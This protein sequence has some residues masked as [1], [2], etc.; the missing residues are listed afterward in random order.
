MATHISR[1]NG[2]L[3]YQTI[4]QMVEAGH[5]K[6]SQKANI[7][8]ASLDL[9]ISDEIYEV[10]GIFQPRIGETVRDVLAHLN[11]K[12]HPMSEPLEIEQMYLVKLNETMKLP[13]TVYG[14]CNPKSTT[15]RNDVHVRVLVDGVARYDALPHG[16]EG[17]LWMAI[18]PKS[19]RIKLTKGQTLSQLRLFNQ[20][21][22]LDNLEL[23]LAMGQHELLW[24]P[25][26]SVMKF[27]DVKVRDNDSSIILTLDLAADI[28][29]YEAIATK[30]VLDLSKVA[31]H[32]AK[33][34][35]KPIKKSGGFVYLKKGH[36]YILS[37]LESV[38]IPPHLACEMVPMDERSGEFRSHYAGFMDPGWG[39]GKKGEG[40]GRPFTL[41]VRP[42]EDLMVRNGQPIS[43]IRFEKV[44][45][46]PELL[47]DGTSSN[48]IVQSGPKLS[49][50]FKV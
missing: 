7:R 14:F 18:I 4:I 48:Y 10:E 5:I 29:G 45:Q 20:D 39:W 8:P 1:K 22:R 11:K 47:Y 24:R 9:S 41:E 12:K 13:Q 46:I 25:D 44:A 34:F 40:R 38:K 42:F 33:K 35:F 50:H 31:A 37:T 36:F 23:E 30:E 43:K 3:P 49:K 15:G 19:F 2:A 28:L 32:D 16:W 17:E 21:T 6:G 27:E 26:G